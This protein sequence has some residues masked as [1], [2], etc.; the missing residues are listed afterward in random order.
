MG[1][2]PGSGIHRSD[3]GGRTWRKIEVGDL[4]D[5]PKTAFVND[6]KADLFD[7]NTL[8]IILDNHKYG[9]QSKEIYRN[10]LSFGE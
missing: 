9:N 3:D 7:V 10:V 5:V 2:G 8:Y 4:P 6:I 1:G